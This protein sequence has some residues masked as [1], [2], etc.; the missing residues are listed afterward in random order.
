MCFRNDN[1][2]KPQKKVLFLLDSP[3][4]KGEGK[5]LSTQ[6]KIIFFNVFNVFVFFCFFSSRSFDH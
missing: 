5:V 4:K 2:G 3:L 1:I 6:E